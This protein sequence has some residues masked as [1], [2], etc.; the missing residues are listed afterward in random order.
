MAHMR[1]GTPSL[2]IYLYLVRHLLVAHLNSPVF[3]TPKMHSPQPRPTTEDKA[4]YGY[5]GLLGPVH[6]KIDEYKSHL[7]LFAVAINDKPSG[8]RRQLASE[9]SS[10]L[11]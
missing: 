10:S 3:I 5:N 6:L 4:L 8:D 1:R 7:L 9:A 11:K 2:R